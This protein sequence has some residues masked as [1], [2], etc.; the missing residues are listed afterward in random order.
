MLYFESNTINK[1][2]TE[3]KIIVTEL[4]TYVAIGPFG[5]RS[6]ESSVDNLIKI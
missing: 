1:K 2:V 4:P 5:I 3:I 6:D